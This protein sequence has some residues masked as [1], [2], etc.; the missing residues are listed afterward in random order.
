MSHASAAQV[1]G[2]SV[3]LD[4]GRLLLSLV[5][6]VAVPLFV[7]GTNVRWLFT[8]RGFILD[9]FRDNRVDL[10]TRLDA[11]Q[12]ELVA[13]E[14]VNYFTA[15]PGRLDVTVT[16]D[17]RQ[18]P[19]F[20]EREVRHMEDVQALVQVFLRLQLIA[21]VAIAAR[22]LFAVAVERSMKNL[23]LDL[24]W[25]AGVMISV[26]LLVG[27]LALIDFTSLWTMFHRIA[28]RNELW[29]LDPRT[30]YLIMLFPEPFWFV[31]TM[32]MALGTSSMTLGA[33]L[34]GFLLWRFA[35]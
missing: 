15:P 14:F 9:G 25:S 29:L 1:G 27:V 17:G 21:A 16:V 18:R 24:M 6:V 19:L 31:G 34:G 12:L 22:V 30:D 13:A 5:F 20:N 23:G 4:W 28:F 3:A 10:T 33:A 2:A 35:P 7:V 32:R 26:V 11:R 8:D